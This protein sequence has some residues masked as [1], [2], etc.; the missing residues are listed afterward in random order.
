M[1]IAL[2]LETLPPLPLSS[3]NPLDIASHEEWFRQYATIERSVC[4]HDPYPEDL[5]LE[6]SFNVLAHAREIAVSEGY[7]APLARACLLA[8]LYHDLARF[9]QYRVWK[10]FKDAA[11]CN[12][13]EE[14]ARLAETYQVLQHEPF[15]AKTVL[16]AIRLHNAYHLPDDLAYDAG[17][18]T[19]VTRDADKIDIIRIMADH[20]AHKPYEPT[21]V[22]SLPDDPALFS[23]KVIDCALNDEVAGYADLASVNDFR[24]LLGSWFNDMH[25]PAAKRIMKKEGHM[26]QLIEALPDAHYGRAR[27]HL[28]ELMQQQQC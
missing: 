14:G 12:H 7:A 28:L 27:D 23:Q 26:V 25:S 6:H 5:K 3:K 22:L 13:G 2:S 24:L 16:Q 17:I 11:S 19:R 21:V 8:G 15:V 20:L 4:P 9:A 10:T 1:N 18:V